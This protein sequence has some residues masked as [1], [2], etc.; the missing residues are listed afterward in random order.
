LDD[1]LEELKR[2]PNVLN[3]VRIF[4]TR[5]KVYYLLF[6]ISI[7]ILATLI[8]LINTVEVTESRTMLIK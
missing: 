1:L 4:S 2:A 5:L 8:L 6:F 3:V 7:I